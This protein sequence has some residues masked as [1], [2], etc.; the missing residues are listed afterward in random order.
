MAKSES[1]GRESVQDALDRSLDETGGSGLGNSPLKESGTGDAQSSS[2]GAPAATQPVDVKAEGISNSKV[3][4][5]GTLPLH[6][7]AF[8]DNALAILSSEMKNWHGPAQ[9]LRKNYGSPEEQAAFKAQLDIQFPV[10]PELSYQNTAILPLDTDSLLVLRLSDLGF[11]TSHSSK[12][13]PFLHTCLELLDEY[14]TNTVMT[15]NDPLLLCQG[16][17]FNAEQP[18]PFWAKY[19]KGCARAC[20]MLF[21][22][23][24]ILERGWAV[25]TLSPDL[26]RSLTAIYSRREILSTDSQSIALAN[27][28]LSR[29]GAIR[30][31]HCVLTWLGKL[32]LLQSKGLKAE[33]V[34]KAW[35]SSATQAGQLQGNKRVAVLQLLNMP[36]AVIEILLD[37]LS[38]FGD[39]SAFPED[40]FSNKKLS[41]GARYRSGNKTWNDR[42]TI[43]A[44]AVVMMLKYIHRQHQK[45]LPG[46]HQKLRKEAL[47]EALH[48][49]QLLVSLSA[50]LLAQ[51][52]VA[53]HLLEEEATSSTYIRTFQQSFR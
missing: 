34:L 18:P 27:A 32:S 6:P 36:P 30:K 41:I 35:N 19:V 10:R 11:D 12:P 53:P 25:E 48:M 13:T 37:H 2:Q 46:T 31:A 14:L 39:K 50:E 1:P 22:A 42:L 7:E 29:Q 26:Q 16:E 23:S 15:Q 43:S 49:S 24:Q 3:T 44:E 28:K 33:E 51:N 40:A 4:V 9:Y 47:E 20:T 52:P 38:E 8:R 21:L 5:V 17:S 45:K